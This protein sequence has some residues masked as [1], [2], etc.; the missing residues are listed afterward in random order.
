MDLERK[1]PLHSQVT[2][3]LNEKISTLSVF[4]DMSK[5]FDFV[6]HKRLLYK[7]ERCGIRG[8]ALDWFKNYLS[9]RQQTTVRSKIENNSKT[10]YESEM[11]PNNCRVPQVVF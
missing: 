11:K 8:K 6:S 2:E 1:A 4:L 10:T 7:L 5:A 3:A 9:N